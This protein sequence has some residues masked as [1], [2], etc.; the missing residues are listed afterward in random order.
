MS[1]THVLVDSS[2][3]TTPTSTG[4]LRSRMSTP[5]AFGSSPPGSSPPLMSQASDS[6]VTLPSQPSTISSSLTSPNQ[7][8]PAQPSPQLHP[9]LPEYIPSL[10]QSYPQDLDHE[11]GLELLSPPSSRSE[12]PFSVLSGSGAANSPWMPI[13]ATPSPFSALH[14]G[15]GATSPSARPTNISHS[16][17]P[18]PGLL[19]QS[20]DGGMPANLAY[21]Q[22]QQN[23][24]LE[25]STAS[26]TSQY[27]S[28]PS[29][30][31]VSGSVSTL[32]DQGSGLSSPSTLSSPLQDQAA[33]QRSL[34]SLSSL[35]PITFTSPNPAAYIPQRSFPSTAAGQGTPPRLP[36]SASQPRSTLVFGTATEGDSDK[37]E[38]EG[39]P[40][41][42]RSP[43]SPHFRGGG[44]LSDLDFMSDLDE[45][46]DAGRVSSPHGFFEVGNL[47][48]GG[49]SISGGNQ[50]LSPMSQTF[51]D[52]RQHDSDDPRSPFS[53]FGDLESENGFSDSGMSD[54]SW[55]SVAGGGSGHRDGGSH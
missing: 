16:P 5:P 27:H 17:P 13:R 28:F 55:G 26:V 29:S 6:R 53:D 19:R 34:S 44:D 38:G 2:A 11:H 14:S 12:S 46:S 20:S 31:A 39:T 51:L 33:S 9:L 22:H 37:E 41:S 3:P 15:A 50:A 49:L 1:P 32:S 10:S 36:L 8:S 43:V 42:P 52:V 30:P 25:S 35:S 7:S 4:T 21:Q 40:R 23:Q 48:H 54:S 45:R 47:D 18:P 24:A